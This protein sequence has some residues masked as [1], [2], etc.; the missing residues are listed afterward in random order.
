[1]GSIRDEVR[2]FFDSNSEIHT[3]STCR[4]AELHTGP[5]L[6]ALLSPFRGYSEA[7]CH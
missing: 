4:A 1:M 3:C 5:N 7:G 2:C 6:K